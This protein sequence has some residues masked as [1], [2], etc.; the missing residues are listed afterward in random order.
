MGAQAG[1]AV[2]RS[3]P[4]A[5]LGFVVAACGGVVGSSYARNLAPRLTSSMASNSRP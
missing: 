4:L 2:E 5:V 3:R 1:D